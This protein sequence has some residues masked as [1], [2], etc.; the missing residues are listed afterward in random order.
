MTRDSCSDFSRWHLMALQLAGEPAPE[1]PA[2]AGRV[3]K[4]DMAAL[5]NDKTDPLADAWDAQHRL[6]DE[7]KT[8]PPGLAG[9]GD[10]DPQALE[11]RP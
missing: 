11:H 4:V 2:I 9:S 6:T 5:K 3:V 7:P 8:P 1:L 10:H